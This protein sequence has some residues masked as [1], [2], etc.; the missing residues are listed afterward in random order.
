VLSESAEENDTAFDSLLPMPKTGDVHEI[1]NL[2]FFNHL[3]IFVIVRWKS[4]RMYGKSSPQL[5]F[6]A[7]YC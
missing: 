6:L 4:V 3:G 1:A 5:P 2:Y 7:L